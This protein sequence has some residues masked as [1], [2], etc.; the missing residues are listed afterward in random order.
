MFMGSLI[1]QFKSMIAHINTIAFQGMI[2]LP[3]DVQVQISP[4]LPAFTIVGLADKAV[5][6]S[7]ERV[8]ASFQ[9]LGLDIPPKRITVNLAPA[10]LQK[11]G[12]HY[13]LAIALGLMVAL[14]IL[15]QE[16]LS[17][18]LVLGELGLDG[19]ISGVAGVL[20]AAMEAS[21]Q[22]V[23]LICPSSCAQEAVWAGNLSILAP[24]NLLSLV[25]HF[26]GAQVLSQPELIPPGQAPPSSLDLQD[27]KGQLLAKRALEI[28]AAGGHNLLMMGPPG[29]G[30]SMLAARLPSILPPLPPKEAL[31]ATMIHSLAGCLPYE[32]LIRHP[33]FRE[34]HHSASLPA[35]IGG[36]HK[37]QPGEISLAHHGVLFL[38]ELPEFQRA[39]LEA[40]RQPMETGRAV[41]ARVNSHATFPASF[42]LIAAMNPCR[43][44]YFGDE[45]RACSRSPR[46]AQDYQN[47]ISGPLLDRFDLIIDVPEISAQDLVH[48]PLWESSK[49]V[50]LRV[51][52]ARDYQHQRSQDLPPSHATNARINS[53]ILEKNVFIESNAHHLLL[54]A[55][56]KFKISGRGYY[57]ILRVSR[58]IADLEQHPSVTPRHIAEA[59]SFR[60]VSFT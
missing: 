21:S 57:R 41:I 17:P 3:V 45:S 32:G 50:A 38:D 26:K 33:P 55:M 48:G 9:A 30:K 53:K 12:S 47:K 6:E 37:C 18:Y 8:R 16:D 40:L 54:Q 24:A 23:G 35:L 28:A 29:A 11:E 4:G 22:D 56:E 14:H 20:L 13:D 27:I 34:P 46:C 2:A 52:N 44:G 39:T 10:D 36:G 7:R 31:E 43:C 59:L 19:S 51:A 42:Q 49:V 58:T 60:K 25:N 15:D 1:L 5:V